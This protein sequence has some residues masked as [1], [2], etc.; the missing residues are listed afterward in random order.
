M[1]HTKQTPPSWWSDS[2][3]TS[4]GA[5]LI[6]TPNPTQERC[7]QEVWRG[8]GQRDLDKLQTKKSN[9]LLYNLYDLKK[10]SQIDD[11]IDD[12]VAS[13]DTS[14]C[15]APKWVHPWFH[16]KPLEAAIGQEPML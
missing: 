10:C 1:D 8:W 7:E 15:A 12:H 16:V 2:P 3:S 13:Y 6:V 5:N 4:S 9:S 14:R 11:D